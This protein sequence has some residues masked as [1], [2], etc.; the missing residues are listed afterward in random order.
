MAKSLL[1]DKAIIDLD[2]DQQ[3]IA[4]KIQAYKSGGWEEVELRCAYLE[5]VKERLADLNAVLDIVRDK[6]IFSVFMLIPVAK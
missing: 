1:A 6:K 3:K 5:N 4:I 2:R